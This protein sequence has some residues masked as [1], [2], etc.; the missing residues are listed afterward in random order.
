[1][2]EIGKK[3]FFG[4]TYIIAQ[5]EEDKMYGVI[6]LEDEDI[7]VPFMFQ[8]IIFHEHEPKMYTFDKRSKNGV[9]HIFEDKIRI[10]PP[11]FEKN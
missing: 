8:N 1:M 5:N 11:E 2:I 6:R 3:K 9:I 10:Y 4:Q 7:V